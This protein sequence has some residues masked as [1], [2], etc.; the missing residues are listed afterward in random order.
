MKTLKSSRPAPHGP[1]TASTHQ[2]DSARL[3]DR[4]GQLLTADHALAAADV[5]IE[6]VRNRKH[7]PFVHYRRRQW[8][9]FDNIGI[10][11]PRTPDDRATIYTWLDAHPWM[12][13]LTDAVQTVHRHR[14]AFQMLDPNYASFLALKAGEFFP[15]H[16]D[17]GPVHKR[18]VT[19]LCGYAAI[20]LV[21]IRDGISTEFVQAPG[22]EYAMEMS[23]DELD[24]V[25]HSV[26]VLGDSTRLN[27]TL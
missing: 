12:K 14:E 21:D 25:L 9:S 16:Q 17:L 19:T 22:Q 4:G 2:F 23:P 7:F 18:S 8:A 15:L 27:M 26:M 10:W 1:Q 6:L 5:V 24:A 3:W 13:P 20:Q 11:E